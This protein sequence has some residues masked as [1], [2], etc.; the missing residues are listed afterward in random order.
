M[1]EHPPPRVDI[2]RDDHGDEGWVARITIDNPTRLNVLNTETAQLVA[3]AFEEISSDEDLRAVV[4]TG[5]GDRAFIGGAD[6]KE[7]G[8]LD[9]HSAEAFITRIH[10]ACQAVRDCPV[11]VIARIR[12]FCLG[13]GLEVA[14]SCDMRIASDDSTFGMPEV[15]VGVPSVIEAALLPRLVGWGKTNQLLLTGENIDA[16]EAQRCRLVENVTTPDALDSQVDAYV[17]S[18]V[19]AAPQA[20]RLQKVLIRR[21]EELNLKESV[22]LGIEMFRRAFETGEPAV[23]TKPFLDRKKK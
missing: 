21:W 5:A 2:V 12:G 13:A 1:T 20:I 10:E 3:N 19:A 22:D 18:I 14:A 8:A 7:F 16:E 23:Y 11:P 15:K 17:A 6:I 9:P 4:L